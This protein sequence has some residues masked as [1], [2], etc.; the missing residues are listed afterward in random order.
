VYPI[1][2]T[3]VGCSQDVVSDT[4]YLTVE[5][6]DLVVP[7]VFT[8]NGDGFNDHFYIPNIEYYPNS[9][10][11][12]FNRWGRKVYQSTNYQGDWDGEKCA[13]GV[14]YYVL[15][16]SYGDHGNGEQTKQQ[17]GTVTILR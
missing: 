1:I 5:P 17:S 7:N 9:N 3:V 8:P 15:T 14:Y 13:D 10:M 2:L 11:M 4:M 6:C 12:I 16:I